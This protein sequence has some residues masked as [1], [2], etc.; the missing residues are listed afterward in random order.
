MD[1]KQNISLIL[2]WAIRLDCSS[3]EQSFFP[4]PGVSILRAWVNTI[5]LDLPCEYGKPIFTVIEKLCGLPVILI[6]NPQRQ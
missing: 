4:D 6:R 3:G 1:I 2:A 5:F